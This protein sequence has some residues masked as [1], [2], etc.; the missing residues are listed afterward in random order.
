M[1]WVNYLLIPQW[2]LAIVVSR[3]NN[4]IPEYFEEAL[5]ELVK[6]QKLDMGEIIEK[7]F[8]E[9]NMREMNF[10]TRLADLASCL[11]ETDYE[12]F[13]LYWIKKRGIKYEIKSEFDVKAEYL[14]KDGYRVIE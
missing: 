13:L 2:K 9:L 3:H 8:N 14:K 5:D 6:P 10:I 7:K 11:E 1:G 12:L 4:E